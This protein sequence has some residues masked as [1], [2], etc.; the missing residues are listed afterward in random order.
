MLNTSWIIDLFTWILHSTEQTQHLNCKAIL[1]WR[2]SKEFYLNLNISSLNS[3]HAMEYSFG[4]LNISSSFTSVTE[5]SFWCLITM[6]HSGS[7]HYSFPVYL[8][9]DLLNPPSVGQFFSRLNWPLCGSIWE[10]SFFSF[11]FCHAPCICNSTWH[12]LKSWEFPA[13][14]A[15]PSAIRHT[16]VVCSWC[17]ILNT[18]HSS[19]HISESI[20]VQWL[21]Q[22]L[23]DLYS[24]FPCFPLKS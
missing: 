8:L 5:Q 6:L 16:L 1:T 11:I 12:Q 9:A 19:L 22:V 17:F 20:S 23:D 3:Q 13:G 21:R 4:A 15:T 24:S 14:N 2:L 7:I 18:K 10:P